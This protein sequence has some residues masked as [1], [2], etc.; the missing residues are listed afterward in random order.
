[1]L[2][3]CIAFASGLIAPSL[4]DFLLR[5]AIVEQV[6]KQEGLMK[7]IRTLTA[8]TCASLLVPTLG[9][10]TDQNMDTGIESLDKAVRSYKE[11]TSLKDS[12]IPTS[13]ARKAE[14]V[15]IFPE[16]TTAAL[17]VGGTHGDG[18]AMCKTSTGEW[19]AP[20][21]LDLTGGSIGIQAGGK[22]S[23]V[24]AY[25]MDKNSK[26]KL[27]ERSLQFG[28]DVSAVAGSFE[29][30][31]DIPS[32]GVVTYAQTKGAFAGASLSGV[33]MSVD[34]SEQ[35]AFY[36]G[37]KDVTTISEARLQGSR[38]EKVEELKRLLS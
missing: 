9:S 30:S 27:R 13:V 19:G 31:F 2:T 15:A 14:C 21:F 38:L 11:I 4:T 28:G 25:I 24:V 33:S 22:T 17:V 7:I 16:V 37:Q 1:V 32:S 6:Y 23:T 20:I 29:K 34:K 5:G 3:E 10:A 36:E 35:L 12:S 8:L 18:V 26:M